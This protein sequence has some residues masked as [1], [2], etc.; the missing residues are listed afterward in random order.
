MRSHYDAGQIKLKGKITKK[1]SC[2]CEMVNFKYSESIKLAK[3][4]ILDFKKG[5]TDE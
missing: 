2:W 3:K 5:K 1:L 4:Y